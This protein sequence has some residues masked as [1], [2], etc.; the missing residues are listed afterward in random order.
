MA[1]Q[2][3]FA[4]S[5]D[6][7]LD[8]LAS[9]CTDKSPKGFLDAPIAD[10][11]EYI[12][13]HP[14]YVT[15]SSCSGRIVLYATLEKQW[16]FAKHGEASDSE[17]LDA[18]GQYYS[19]GH[20]R[21]DYPVLLKHEPF[22][23]HV[24]C[25]S[26]KAAEYLLQQVLQAGFRE[27]GIVLGKKKIMVGVRTNAGVM[28][29]P[30]V[31]NI[32]ETA[33]GRDILKYLSSQAR[34]RFAHNEKRIEQ[35]F[36][37]MKACLSCDHVLE[38]R[39]FNFAPTRVSTSGTLVERLRRWSH[40]S[41]TDGE[42]IYIFGGYGKANDGHVGRLGDF[43]IGS[44]KT[45]RL[46]DGMSW[47]EALPD[48]DGSL[49]PTPRV[50]HTLTYLPSS[51]AW[52]KGS[53]FILFGGRSSPMEA[54]SDV[55]ICSVKQINSSN[56]ASNCYSV[57]WIPLEIESAGTSPSER[58]GHTAT[59]IC[60]E[61]PENQRLLVYGGRDKNRVFGDSHLLEVCGLSASWKSLELVG[62]RSPGP[63]FYHVSTFL[64]GSSQIVLSG[65]CISLE[66]SAHVFSNNIYILDLLSLNWSTLDVTGS[67]QSACRYSHT[68][69]HAHGT[70]ILLFG[71][72][73]MNGNAHGLALLD[74]AAKTL[75]NLDAGDFNGSTTCVRHS[76][77]SVVTSN[78][79]LLLIKVGGG[80]Q[81]LGFGQAWDDPV[82][83]AI[84]IS[85]VGGKDTEFP[86]LSS[87]VS[88]PAGD[89]SISEATEVLTVSAIV[90][91]SKHVKC[92][93]VALEAMEGLNLNFRIGSVSGVWKDVT[94]PACLADEE[95]ILTWKV[96][97]LTPN[98][99][100]FLSENGQKISKVL[101]PDVGTLLASNRAFFIQNVS[102]LNFPRT[103]VL[104]KIKD[105]TQENIL[106]VLK[107]LFRDCNVV[108]GKGL[109]SILPQKLERLGSDVI[110]LPGEMFDDSSKFSWG[111]MPPACLTQAFSEI[112]RIGRVK[113]ILCRREVDKG[114]MRQSCA[115]MLYDP[116]KIGSWISV[117]E[118]GVV[119]NFDSEEVMF[120]TGNG[121]EKR[122]VGN[123]KCENETIVD[124]YAG[125][126]YF[127]L[128][129]LVNGKAKHVYACEINPESVKALRKN[130]VA[131]NVAERCTVF[132]GDNAMSAPKLCGIADR[133]NLGLLPDSV[134]GYELAVD[135]LKLSTGGMLHI[136]GNCPS[137]ERLKWGEKT[138]IA[139]QEIV[140][141][142][143]ELL[144][145]WEVQCI[146]VERVKSYAPRVDHVVGDIKCTP[147]SNTS[148]SSASKR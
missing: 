64:E 21:G 12:N 99:S 17:I 3:P 107:Q 13:R 105:Q 120:C 111:R 9:G 71:G 43:L 106:S 142:R 109:L 38:R 93:K 124:L 133:V 136:H 2:S 127:T 77:N 108:D 119:Y 144:G 14:D 70:K 48:D 72:I 135:C 32:I 98:A 42:N 68:A 117:K 122:R 50:R 147:V 15:T 128:P 6:A 95:E 143:G 45:G 54:F 25:V 34:A 81:C 39:A 129:F 90:T 28:E 134:K 123:F 20:E 27:S 57:S 51:E 140:D 16:V 1:S 88:S 75:K 30:L 65:G 79:E 85:A 60:N 102:A 125:I 35:F 22:I 145:H 59:V 100:I 94:I 112:A 36:D 19:E 84:S 49:W 56:D 114:I 47:V 69:A 89:D 52:S 24:Q 37:V 103:K 40:A 46:Q 139:I 104:R 53:S 110:V 118:N 116:S 87:V 76:S 86:P 29:V 131:N 55:H 96:L 101:G 113:R 130:L 5:K 92:I 11:V 67:P 115:K 74:I 148:I 4:R 138:R 44:W 18:L 63:L 33:P 23:L 83:S 78:G 91:S 141:S 146:H 132:L 41:A 10:L 7:I 97:P 8:K 82:V 121:T 58:W 31:A 73:R 26:L 62:G 126:G 66:D 137:K 61:S 80:S